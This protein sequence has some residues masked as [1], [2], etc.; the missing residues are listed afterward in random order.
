MARLKCSA[1]PRAAKK[2]GQMG[3]QTRDTYPST[4]FSERDRYVDT[5]RAAIIRGN[6]DLE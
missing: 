1:S 4:A 6:F 5:L 3:P 2:S